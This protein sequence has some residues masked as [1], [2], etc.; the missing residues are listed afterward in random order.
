MQKIHSRILDGFNSGNGKNV[1][2][3][4]VTGGGYILTEYMVEAISKV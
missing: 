2:Y 3:T 4:W 1:T